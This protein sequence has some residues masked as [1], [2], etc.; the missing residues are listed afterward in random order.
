MARMLEEALIDIKVT[1]DACQM[2]P[3]TEVIASLMKQ[4]E[5]DKLYSVRA[6]EVA[7]QAEAESNRLRELLA[8]NGGIDMV[9]EEQ[10]RTLT[11]LAQ[12][13]KDEMET[14]KELESVKSQLDVAVKR[15]AALER[16]WSLHN[17]MYDAAYANDSLHACVS[18]YRLAKKPFSTS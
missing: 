9:R 1:K 15:N 3:D 7:E 12:K 13:Q 11:Q 18:G 6:L 4:S 14:R 17:P 8:R 10:E 2:A 16:F 5:I